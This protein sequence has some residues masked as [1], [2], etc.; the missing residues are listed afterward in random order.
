LGVLLALQPVAWALNPARLIT[1][2]GLDVWLTRDGLPQDSVKAILQTRDGYLWLGTWGGLARFDGVRFTVFNRTNT[3]A[4]GDSHITALAEDADGSLWIGTANAGLIRLK[5]GVFES[6]RSEHDTSYEERSRW[7]I[8]SIVPSRDGGL[9]IGTSGGGF[10][11]FKNRRFG[12]LLMDRHVVRDLLEDR[13]GRLWVATST[14]VLELSWL[15]PDQFRVERHLLPDRLVNAIYQDRAGTIWIAAR[16]GLTRVSGERVTTFGPAPGLPIDDVLSIRGD[17]DGN[18]WIGTN[19]YGL[20]RMRGEQFDVLT[21]H[22]GLSNGVVAALNEDREGSLWIGSHGGLNRLRDTR[23]TAITT[24]EGLSADPVNSVVAGRDATIWIGTEGGGLN[25]LQAGRITSYTTADGLPANHVGALFEADD[26]SLWISGDGVVARLRNGRPRLYTREHGVPAGF[27]SAIGETRHGRLILCSEGPVRE[28]RDDRFI[29][30]EQQPPGM[31][32]CYSIT[33][34]RRGSLWFA[35]TGGLV[36]VSDAGHRFYT[37]RDGLPDEGVHSVYEDAAGTMWIATVRGLARL[38]DGRVTSFSNAGPL[39]EV[40][41]EILADDAGHLWM[42]GRQGILKVATRDLEANAAGQLRDIPITVYGFADGL[43][44]TEYTTAY[45]QRPACR[46][47]DGRLW[48]ATIGG[49]VSIDPSV[50]WVNPLPPPVAIEAF[51]AEEPVDVR[52]P[53]EVAA[54]TNSFEIQYTALSLLAPMRVR[55]AYQLEGLDP[56]WIDAGTRRVALYSRVPPG[57]YRFRLRAANNDGVWNE[58]GAS[59]DVHVLPYFYQ[60]AWFQLLVIAACVLAVFGLHRMHV[61]RVEARFA[62]VMKERHRIAREIHDTLAQG[63]AAIGLHLSVIEHEPSATSREHHVETARRLVKASLA[64]A[65]RS[66]WNLRPEYLD[67]SNL[68]SGLARM[69]ADVSEGGDVH[70]DVRT[71]GMPRPVSADVETNMFRIAQEAV[72]NAIRHAAA[73]RILIDLQF[74][75]NTARLAIADDGCGFDAASLADGFGLSSMRDRAAQIGAELRV[76]SRPSGGTSV[77]L[78]APTEA[79]ERGRVTRPAVA[80][81]RGAR[82]RMSTAARAISAVTR[83]RLSRGGPI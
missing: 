12:R 53:V 64:E 11:R 31:E 13:S 51:E 4:L 79:P 26:G 39:G 70:I 25:R 52:R 44:S 71:S 42:N 61:R 68:V 73:R 82:H 7:Q 75:Q 65:R 6:F 34:D 48:F 83:R 77:T 10:R 18:L 32:Y 66:V 62:V 80:A 37:T 15:D 17:R 49:I 76:E 21:R 9:W 19:G 45:I 36:H 55:F 69:A 81:L 24:R 30:F 2:Y 58:A 40:V 33:R 74:N 57:R 28:L 63:L 1:Q 47:S 3:P 54:G 60:T 43:K 22:E 8:R 35:T 56:G 78:T 5:D 20:V 46:T 29:V 23:F 38:K 41:F 14:G 50:D 16:G 67:R 27:V 59:L 72:A